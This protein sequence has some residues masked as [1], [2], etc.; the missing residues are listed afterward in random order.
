MKTVMSMGLPPKAA[1][2]EAW[3]GR[4]IDGRYKVLSLIGEGGMG[5]VFVV[6]HV[7][8]RKRFALKLVRPEIAEEPDFVERFEREAMATAR[9]KHP[10]IAKAQDFGALDNG[11]AYLV[12]ELVRGRSLDG[13]IA[14]GQRLGWREVAEI[15]AQIA[16]ALAAAHEIGIIHRDLKPDN[17]L[18]DGL[19]TG[20]LRVKVLDFGVARI[21]DVASLGV[22]ARDLTRQGSVIGTPGYMAPEQ[23]CGAVA[24]ERSDLYA[25]GV[26][27]WE[28]LA[29]RRLWTGETLT[30]LFTV[31]LGED[32]PAPEAI[33]GLPAAFQV[34]IQQLLDREPTRRPAR[35][36]DLEEV[37]RE[38]ALAP[39]QSMIGGPAPA[40]EAPSSRRG[41]LLGV[42]VVVV[43]VGLVALRI[44]LGSGDASEGG[45]GA[46]D[47]VAA[48]GGG[49]DTPVPAALRDAEEVLKSS[50]DRDARAKAGETVRDHE[51]AEVPAYLRTVAAIAVSE[52][53]KAQA[54]LV[55]E[56]GGGGDARAL[57]ALESLSAMSRELC[58]RSDPRCLACLQ[59]PLG[60]AIRGLQSD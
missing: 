41:I 8:L 48:A 54:E 5:A 52:E 13:V 17:V 19:G 1:G 40:A 20:S 2:P 10:R 15:G 36:R 39:E 18:V 21:Q 38:F 32:A 24:S 37:L 27:L 3:I 49:A 23:A 50:T 46:A 30:D 59:G 55:E 7:S 45:G 60:E 6:E 31:Q 42:V 43:L 9:L 57:P 44:A 53:C 12:M 25:V 4:V 47:E 58:K 28:L 29:G 11:D 51:P 22:P 56:L 16:G 14:A 26:I 34:L 33:D 35:A